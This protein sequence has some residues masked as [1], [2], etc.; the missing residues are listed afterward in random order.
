MPTQRDNDQVARAAFG[1]RVDRAA[2]VVPTV[3]Q[4][5]Q[6]IFTITGGRILLRALVGEITTVF[7]GTVYTLKVTSSPAA[8]GSPVDLSTALTMTSFTLGAHVT[9]GATVGAALSHDNAG[10]ATLLLPVPALLLPAG[11]I[12]LTGSATQTGAM[13]WSLHYV[14]LDSGAQVVAA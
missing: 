8:N 5:P 14:A 2:A 12:T 1:W 10:N 11:A 3:A 7:S 4:S 6:T 9:L 13:K